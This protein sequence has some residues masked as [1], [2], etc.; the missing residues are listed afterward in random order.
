MLGDGVEGDALHGFALERTLLG[1]H[2][3][4]VPGNGFAFAVR[5]GG[6]DEAVSAF[7]RIGDIGHALGGF[8]INFPFHGEIFIGADG[9]VFGGKVA[10]VAIGGENDEILAQIFVDGLGLGGR[11]NDDNSHS[12]VPVRWGFN[13]KLA[14]NAF[15]GDRS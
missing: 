13:P 12:Q 9:A 14:K 5:V 6:E 15:K 4:Q 7:Q 11:L 8:G 1:E 10:D 3:H 2:V